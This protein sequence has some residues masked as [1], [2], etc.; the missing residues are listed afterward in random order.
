MADSEAKSLIVS[1][2][3][4]GV[5]HHFVWSFEK[6]KTD[7]IPCFLSHCLFDCMATLACLETLLRIVI[8]SSETQTLNPV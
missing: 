5:T 7:T 4:C 8:G 2:S 3:S 6:D 1:I